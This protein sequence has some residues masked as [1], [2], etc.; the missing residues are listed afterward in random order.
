[1]RPLYHVTCDSGKAG[2]CTRKVL[3]FS[4]STYSTTLQTDDGEI[5]LDFSKNLINQEV[6]DMLLAMVNTHTH[7]HALKGHLSALIR[8][9]LLRS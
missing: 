9:K 5:L 2:S 3:S 7:T 4:V 6:L 8:P 1:M